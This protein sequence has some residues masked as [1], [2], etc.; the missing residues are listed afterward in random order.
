MPGFQLS[1]KGW[2]Y[3]KNY[4]GSEWLQVVRI[5]FKQNKIQ[6]LVLE[7]SQSVNEVA[8]KMNKWI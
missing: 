2:E 8:W 4:H 3:T 1:L 7:I 6:I 5:V